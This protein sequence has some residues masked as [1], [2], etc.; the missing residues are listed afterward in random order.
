M[1][2][3]PEDV[4]DL[5]WRDGVEFARLYIDLRTGSHHLEFSRGGRPKAFDLA[6]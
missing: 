6:L 4:L 3:S 5:R 1:A 2:A